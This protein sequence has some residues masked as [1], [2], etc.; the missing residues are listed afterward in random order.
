[1]SG[2]SYGGFGGFPQG[3]TGTPSM[4]GGQTQ[5]PNPRSAP[6]AQNPNTGWAPA[7]TNTTATPQYP[8]LQ[9]GYWN[10]LS[11][12]MAGPSY[13]AAPAQQSPMSGAPASIQ[14]YLQGLMGGYTGQSQIQPVT[15]P[16]SRTQ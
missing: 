4:S 15:A 14:N 7:A 13:Q 10:Q 6:P 16:Q 9:G 11:Q 5:S 8:Q 2:G 3:F 1:M 12:M